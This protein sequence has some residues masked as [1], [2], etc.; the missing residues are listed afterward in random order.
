MVTDGYYNIAK[1]AADTAC[2]R[3]ATIKKTSSHDCFWWKAN[4]KAW[5]A[6]EIWGYQTREYDRHPATLQKAY[7]SALWKVT[8]PII[9]IPL[10]IHYPVKHSREHTLFPKPSHHTTLTLPLHSLTLPFSHLYLPHNGLPLNLG[11]IILW[12]ALDQ[13]RGGAN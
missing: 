12:P 5:E 3:N 4:K 11:I 2:S 6:L 1:Q 13:R 7:R 9:L 10:A 8:D